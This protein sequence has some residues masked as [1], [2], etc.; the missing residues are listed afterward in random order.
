M[1]A[2]IK[3]ALPVAI[4][5]DELVRTVK[6]LDRTAHTMTPTETLCAE[7]Q[8]AYSYFNRSL[9]HDELPECML[10]IDHSGKSVYGYFKPC[11]FVSKDGVL[12][13]QISMNPRF[14]L[15]KDLPT[16]LSTLAHE[17]CH[18]WVFR[19]TDRKTVNG[20]HCKRW[21]AKMETMGLV[22]SHTG[23]KG[24]RKTGY[25]MSDYIAP[26]GV[27]ERVCQVLF[28]GGFSLTWGMAA[29]ELVREVLN[30]GAPKPGEKDRA[31]GKV[32]FVCPTCNK[33][34]WAAPS[35]NLICGDDSAVMVRVSA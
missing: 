32:K 4:N 13:D 26:G 31:K 33:P 7:L 16:V 14:L 9:F 24:G 15:E 23:E 22:P 25:R 1:S 10:T 18:L 20:Y 19:C 35:R 12:V 29:E 6:N 3:T 27:F 2:L 21:G 8:C 5:N 17:M 28:D 30:I 34:A 11:G